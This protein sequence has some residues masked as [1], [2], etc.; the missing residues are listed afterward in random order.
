MHQTALIGFDK[1][2]EPVITEFFSANVQ[3]SVDI[4][5]DNLTVRSEKQSSHSPA[6]AKNLIRILI[7]VIRQWIEVKRRL[8][9]GVA[10][11][12]NNHLDAVLLRLV[13]NHMDQAIERNAHKILIVDLAKVDVLLPPV[14][15]PDDNGSQVMLKE[16]LHNEAGNLVQVVIDAANALHDL[17]A[18]MR[19]L[20][21][22]LKTC[23]VLV[24]LGVDAFQ[25]ATFDNHGMNPADRRSKSDDIAKPN[26]N[27]ARTAAVEQ[28]GGRT[29]DL[30]G[31]FDEKG[32]P[33]RNNS[34]VANYR[35][36]YFGVERLIFTRAD[37]QP[38]KT[39]VVLVG[40]NKIAIDN[41]I[42]IT[43]N[44]ESSIL[45][46]VTRQSRHR[47]ELARIRQISFLGL[48]P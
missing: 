45:F 31:Q 19:L 27:Q 46:A 40:D 16:K 13:A 32:V 12:T 42:A 48:I 41:L 17:G 18:T 34:H 33:V 35:F 44:D 8:T 7:A 21:M 39:N 47:L 4:R 24:V 6:R 43:P 36:I 26:I 1:L 10:F 14:V 5:V 9:R 28:D 11:L 30:I 2:F 3:A 37:W 23:G 20:S 38:R 15:M 22:S 25:H 29:S